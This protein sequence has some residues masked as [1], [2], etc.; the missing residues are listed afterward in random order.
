MDLSIYITYNYGNN[1]FNA[2]KLTNSRI[3]QENRNAL[4]VA[5]SDKRFMTINAAGKKVTDPVEL[6]A[7]N[8]GK[9][10][11]SMH[12]SEQG[13]MYIHSWAIEDG[14]Y[15]KLNNVTIGYT[16]PRKFVNKA[17]I[18]NL[19]VYATGSNLLTLTKYSGF[20]PEVSTF[21]SG[22]TPGVDFG[23]YPRSRSF[24]LGLNITF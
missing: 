19:R 5:S 3:G 12:D 17:G 14:S 6:A 7:I 21:R 15:I 1:V 13:S 11:A 22:L 16:L 2:T 4:A 9:T 8:E 20:D 10:F 24:V 18:N 23:G